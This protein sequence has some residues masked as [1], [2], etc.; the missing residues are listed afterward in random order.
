MTN[1][2]FEPV[3]NWVK[4]SCAN[5]SKEYYI[6][7]SRLKY[8]RGVYCSRGCASEIKSKEYKGRKGNVLEGEKNP[9][10]RG[11]KTEKECPICRSIFYSRSAKTCS[12]ECGRKLRS[13]TISGENNPFARKH[14]KTIKK[15]KGCG[16]EYDSPN[17]HY[18]S[19]ECYLKNSHQG[20]YHYQVLSELK[21]LGFNCIVEKTWNWL[22]NPETNNK[23]KVDIFLKDFKIAIE[24]DGR[25]HFVDIPGR[26]KLSVVRKRDLIK[27]NLLEEKEINLIRIANKQSIETIVETINMIVD[28]RDIKRIYLGYSDKFIE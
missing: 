15:C 27:N 8:G 2:S 11:G 25:H 22:R 7:P 21:E 19:N 14:P 4:C 26:S 1:I 23:L 20:V 18:C 13:Q 6:Q 12:L 28:N 10:W 16:K 9:N 3:D 17:K 24:I 5:C